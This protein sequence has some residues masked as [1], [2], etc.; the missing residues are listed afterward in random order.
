M[1][2]AWGP[3]MAA[4]NKAQVEE[5]PMFEFEDMLVDDTEHLAWETEIRRNTVA[6]EEFDTYSDNESGW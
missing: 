3:D 4:W 5:I 1:R 2:S 6:L